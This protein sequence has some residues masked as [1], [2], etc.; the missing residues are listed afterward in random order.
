[1]LFHEAIWRS[2]QL[3]DFMPRETCDTDDPKQRH[4]PYAPFP[5][6]YF[7]VER[8]E[9]GKVGTSEFPFAL[10][11][12]DLGST[13]LAL[14][15]RFYPSPIEH[16]F[17]WRDSERNHQRR[18]SHPLLLYSI[19]G[20]WVSWPY[21]R[22]FCVCVSIARWVFPAQFYTY[23]R[24]FTQG[25]SNRIKSNPSNIDASGCEIQ[26]SI[27]PAWVHPYDDR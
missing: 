5:L 1:M 13:F 4:L 27:R 22:W 17:F 26:T 19:V 24:A 25:W 21:W 2:A 6:R 9:Y 8:G 7:G 18:Y 3:L 14:L 10:G 16:L 20:V 15:N 12:R 11:Y 23:I